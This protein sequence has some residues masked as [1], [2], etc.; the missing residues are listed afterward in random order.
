MKTLDLKRF[1]LDGLNLIE[2][3]AGTGKTYALSNIYLRHLLEKKRQVDQILVVTFTKAATQELRERIRQS[4]QVLRQ[5]FQA[6]IRGESLAPNADPTL[7]ALLERSENHHAD[8]YH[9]LLA[10]RQMDQAEIYTIHGFC[11]Q[12]LQAQAFQLGVPFAQTLSEDV[13][14][15]WEQEAQAMWREQILTLDARLVLYLRQKYPTPQALLQK[16]SSLLQRQPTRILPVLNPPTLAHWVDCFAEQIRW[17]DALKQQSLAHLPE[18]IEI[19]QT[20]ELKNLKHKLTWLQQIQSWC[21][22]Q[23]DLT[24]PTN[25]T[26]KSL[27]AQFTPEVLQEQTKKGK[28]RPEHPWFKFLEAHLADIPEPLD[29]LFKVAAYHELSSRLAKAKAKQA[30]LDF[31]DLIASV[32]QVLQT[33][34]AQQVA[35]LVRGVRQQYHCALIDEF[36]DTDAKQYRIFSTLFA[37]EIGGT[38]ANLTL[39]GDPKQAIYAFRGGD[40]QTYLRAKS[41]FKS[42]A[43]GDLFTMDTNWRSSPAMVAAVNRVFQQ[44]EQPFAHA[45]IPFIEVKAARAE[46]EKPWGSALQL[47][48]VESEG[49]NK[50]DIDLELAHRSAQEVARLLSDEDTLQLKSADVAIL[51]RTAK[52]AELMQAVLSQYGVKASYEARLSIYDSEEAHFVHSLLQSV[53]E[54]SNLFLAKQCLASPLFAF[55]DAELYQQFSHAD[56]LAKLSETLHELHTVWDKQGVLSLLRASMDRFQVLQHWRDTRQAP[57]DAA[58]SWERSL[59]NLN[60]LAE[61]LQQRAREVHGHQSLIRWLRDRIQGREAVNDE[62][63]I[64]LESDEAL[65]QIVTIHKSK[66]LEYPVVFLPFMYQERPVGEAWYYD[67]QGNRCLDLSGSEEHLGAAQREQDQENMRLFYVAMTR[68]KYRCYLG[69]SDYGTG[70]GHKNGLASTAWG[71][72]LLQGSLDASPDS[73]QDKVQ[74]LSAAYPDLICLQ[75]EAESVTHKPYLQV[76]NDP[77]SSTALGARSLSRNPE[78]SWKVHSFTALMQEHQALMASHLRLKSEELELSELLASPVAQQGKFLDIFAFPRGSRAGT[79]LHELFESIEF[80]S[81]ELNERFRSSYGSLAALI[82]SKLEAYGLVDASQISAWRDY[83]Q[84]WLQQVLARHLLSDIRL[85]ALA[86]QD[87]L[88]EMAFHFSVEQIDSQAFNRALLSHRPGVEEIA[89]QGFSG[90]FKGAIDLVFR[91]AGKY[92]ILD[93]K[94]NYLGDAVSDYQGEALNRAM[95]DHRYDAQYLIY[96]LALHRH[97]EQRLGDRYS[98]ERDFGGVLYLFLRGLDV[99]G[100]SEDCLPDLGA[101]PASASQHETLPT[102]VYFARPSEAVISLLDHS[103]GGA[104]RV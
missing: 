26:D 32:D 38:S 91:H 87:C 6:S 22:D 85:G 79:F 84:D 88:V 75:Q 45:D 54:P 9:L 3:S 64:R 33:S 19:V 39:I 101:D 41:D 95:D 53:A 97:L 10:E 27:F 56:Q 46:P 86:Q 60:Q 31:D 23:N 28:S 8:L 100:V 61:L 25:S 98:Y 92:Y 7:L 21:L 104:E 71:R 50:A 73:I 69:F 55:S 24:L 102:G 76:V 99:E 63:R 57:G 12:L 18:V 11:Q 94:S 81:G 96:T 72:L 93:Y 34:S 62:N 29:H 66:G 30:T 51:V 74:K 49:V 78:S 13:S 5:L 36:Q 59:S 89:L 80:S 47:F 82:E 42:H 17:F 14:P 2:A 52:Q 1:P 43:Q 44:L 68:A 58:L 35:Q 103:M 65:V 16:L 83:L 67:R 20:S 77:D 40:I 48:C 4:I 90:H 70:K 15:L 37:G